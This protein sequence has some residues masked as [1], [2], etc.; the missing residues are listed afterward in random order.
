MKASAWAVVDERAAKPSVALEAKPAG[1]AGDV[2]VPEETIFG[3]VSRYHAL[4]GHPTSGDT[5]IELLNRRCVTLGTAF[6]SGL[7]RISKDLRLPVKTIEE[8]IEG[9][10]ILPCFRPFMNHAHY[11]R[12]ADSMAVGTATNTK[13]TLGL[14]ASRVGADDVLRFCPVC[15]VADCETIGIATWY[16]AHQFPGVLVCPYHGVSLVASDCLAQRLKR[17]QLFLPP[18]AAKWNSQKSVS[19]VDD[20]ALEK[21]VIVSRLIAQLFLLRGVPV[22][23]LTWR[24]HYLAH[25]VDR[26]LATASMRVRQRALQR[27]L[28]D[29]W[30]CIRNLPPFD[31]IFARCAGD[32]SWLTSLYRRPRAAHHPL[33]HVLLIGFLAESVESF[34]WTDIPSPAVTSAPDEQASTVTECKITALAAEGRSMRQVAKELGLSVNAV[35]V[36]AEKIGIGF[37]RRSKKLDVTVRS[38]VR[39]ALA[40]GDAIA[41]IVNTTGLSASTVNRILGAE[42]DLQTQRTANIRDQ[43]QTQAREKLRAALVAA[44]SGGFKALQTALGADFI[45]LYRHDRAWLQAQRPAT[46]RIVE[47]T[48]SVDWCARDREMVERVRLAATEILDPVRH[49]IRVTLNEI[50][51]CTGNASWLDKYLARLPRT[52]ELLSQILEP[53]AVFRARRLAWREKHNVDALD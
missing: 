34:L 44:P 50:G 21:L 47:R 8:L 19:N 12:I 18:T 29:F 37:T 11:T 5:L 43:R 52:T 1:K 24:N 45:W 23:P 38:R 28:L 20:R 48:S 17:T 13:I 36:K 53:V 41:N 31:G 42:R 22:D 32:D 3:I 46:V 14:L 10:T 15:A 26:D 33:L 27:A 49:P 39:R 30:G 16:R 2:I 25:L 9:H 51:R 6:P 4:T 35:L 40:A 7:N